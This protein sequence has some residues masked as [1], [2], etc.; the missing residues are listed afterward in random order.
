MLTPKQKQI[1]EYLKKCLKKNGYSPSLDE[2]AKHFKLAKSTIHQH[3]E[4]L[5]E[6]GYLEKTDYKARSIELSKNKKSDLVEISLLGTIAAGQPIEAIEISDTTI[7]IS[8]KEI[9]VTKSR[10]E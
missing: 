5:K 7:A 1:L 10:I 2:A 9:S 3:I 4:E 8:K 6:K